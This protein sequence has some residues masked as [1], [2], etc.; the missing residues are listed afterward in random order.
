MDL[1]GVLLSSLYRLWYHLWKP[2][3]EEGRCRS[4]TSSLRTLR[5]GLHLHWPQEWTYRRQDCLCIRHIRSGA[6]AVWTQ[7]CTPD[8]SRHHTCEAPAMILD[9]QH[10]SQ[11]RHYWSRRRSAVHQH[12]CVIPITYSDWLFVLRT[13]IDSVASQNFH[14]T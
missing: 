1:G 5:L 7:R 6:Y 10:V 11:K 8:W 9:S 4:A 13:P 2:L 3:D 12:R 14:Q